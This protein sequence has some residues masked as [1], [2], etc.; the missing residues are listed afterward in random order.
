MARTVLDLESA[1]NPP[2]RPVMARAWRGLKRLLLH[3]LAAAVG[4]TA[5]YLWAAANF[6][7][8]SGERAGYVQKFSKQGWICKT[9][10]G[11]LAMASLPGAMP[12]VFAFSLRDDAVAAEINEHMGSRVTLRYEQHLGLPSC[13]GETPYWVTSVR[14]S[15]ASP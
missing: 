5:L 2:R 6:T 11:E 10:E 9:W 1:P 15:A 14:P 12:Q 7:Y 4:A 8:S 3:A 13:F